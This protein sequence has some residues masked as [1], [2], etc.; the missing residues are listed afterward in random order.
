VQK[1]CKANHWA[2]FFLMR[3]RAIAVLS[4]VTVVIL[5]VISLASVFPTYAPGQ[6]QGQP[7]AMVVFI[8]ARTCPVCAKVRPIVDDLEHQYNQQVDFVRLDVTGDKE[9]E[10]S[11]KKAKSLQLTSFFALY[12]DCYPCVGVFDG[13]KKCLKEL[14]GQ[15]AKEAYVKQ[16]KKALLAH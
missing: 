5:A 12:E 4:K 6:E 15:N 2:G 1:A 8:H 14:F 11:R 13:K 7:K 9:K 10:E 3:N 16:I